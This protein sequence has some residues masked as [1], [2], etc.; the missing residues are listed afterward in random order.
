MLNYGIHRKGPPGH[1]FFFSQTARPYFGAYLYCLFFD[2]A[3]YLRLVARVVEV[4]KNP[5]C[6]L[7]IKGRQAGFFQ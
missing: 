3:F 2:N 6:R 7:E 5:A 1:Y 4:I